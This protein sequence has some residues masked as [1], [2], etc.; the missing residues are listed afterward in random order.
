M[1]SGRGDSLLGDFRPVPSSFVLY[2]EK[3]RRILTDNLGVCGAVVRGSTVTVFSYLNVCLRID[4]SVNFP[5]LQT[6]LAIKAYMIVI[7]KNIVSVPMNRYK[8][9]PRGI[10]LPMESSM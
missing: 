1:T 8:L 4:F 10:V 6:I 7:D 2:S 9:K 3:R 5:F